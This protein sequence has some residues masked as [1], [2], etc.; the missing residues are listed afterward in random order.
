[1]I[2]AQLR[3]D[4]NLSVDIGGD[5]GGEWESNNISLENGVGS[6]PQA[7]GAGRDWIKDQISP[8]KVL[9]MALIVLTTLQRLEGSRDLPVI[10]AEGHAV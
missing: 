8:F 7:Q 4:R 3:Q 2:P 5:I 6:L 9:N 1:M 10:T